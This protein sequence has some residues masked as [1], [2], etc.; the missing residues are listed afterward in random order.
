MGSGS[1]GCVRALIEAGAEVGSQDAGGETP[2]CAAARLGRTECLV[3]LIEAGADVEHRN[4]DGTTPLMLAA[5]SD[6]DEC[7][8]RLVMGGAALDVICPAGRS[9]LVWSAQRGSARA[10]EALLKA[11]A[12][13]GVGAPA[14][15]A[16][17]GG[18]LACL[19][20]LLA[21]GADPDARDA[22]GHT[23]LLVAAKA[24][25]LSELVELVEHTACDMFARGHDG[26]G[27][28]FL[29]RIGGHSQCQDYMR[30]CAPDWDQAMAEREKE[31]LG[32]VTESPRAP[33]RPGARI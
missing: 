27:A 20:R 14:S 19:R 28:M 31:L 10:L 32:T 23:A 33:R 12:S 13:H 11:G 25:R 30:S 15:A 29:A 26:R 17:E 4:S 2:L 3:L 21:A 6:N 9:A 1:C 24:G 5:Q 7:V 16:A 22:C 18:Q 8:E